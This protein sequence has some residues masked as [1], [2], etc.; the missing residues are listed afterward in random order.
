MS[1]EQVGGE[2]RLLPPWWLPVLAIGVWMGLWYLTPGLHAQGLGALVPG[3]S[4][5]ILLET[6]VALVVVAGIALLQ[7]RR[8]A[9]LFA[10][11]RLVWAYALPV[12]LAIALPFH[13]TLP[14]PVAVYMLWMTV[15]VFWQDYLT[16][17]L[18]QSHL[19]DRLPTAVTI[20]LVAVVFYLGHAVLLPES[21][22]PPHVLPALGILA[23]GAVC[24]ALRA[25]A[26]TLHLLLALHLGFYL[27][28]A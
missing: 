19:R 10:R 8:T 14:L 26:R 24:A 2:D 28:F 11:D 20:P 25:R 9:A 22:A 3:E 23:M 21:F 17:G 27:L 4:A 7:R 16:F 1:A 6:A 5:G 15:S 18:L 12:V 13:Y